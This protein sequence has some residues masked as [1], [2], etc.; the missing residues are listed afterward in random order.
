MKGVKTLMTV[1]VIVL[2]CPKN[3][4]TSRIQ[5]LDKSGMQIMDLSPV[6]R[7]SSNEII[8][9]KVDC[10]TQWLFIVYYHKRPR[11]DPRVT[12]PWAKWSLATSRSLTVFWVTLRGSFKFETLHSHFGANCIDSLL[13]LTG[14][15]PRIAGTRSRRLTIWAIS[16]HYK[17]NTV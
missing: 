1:K 9:T 7:W 14:F 8:N 11:H 3:V 4:G 6:L 17:V 16:L 10:S 15:K 12:N 13:P 5:I 2:L